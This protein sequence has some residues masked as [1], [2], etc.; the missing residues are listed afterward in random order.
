MKY[1]LFLAVIFLTAPQSAPANTPAFAHCGTYDSYILL[2][3][4][5]QKFEELGKLHCG[6]SLEITGYDGDFAQVRTTDGRLGWVPNSDLASTAPPRKIS[7]L[8]AGPKGRSRRR[9]PTSLQNIPWSHASAN[10][11]RCSRTWM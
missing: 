4:S 5:V 11:L 1:G 7:S 8:S 3:K 9:S 2:Y 6:E 10:P